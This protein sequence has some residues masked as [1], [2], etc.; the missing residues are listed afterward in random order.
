MGFD[1]DLVV[2]GATAAAQQA[3]LRAAQWQ[4]RVAWVTQGELGICDR[5]N[6]PPPL[7]S[8]RSSA[9]PDRV[10]SLSLAG[11]DVLAQR[12]EFHPH[13]Q[14]ALTV[15][16][17]ALR[18]RFYL[19]ALRPTPILPP[20]AVLDPDVTFTC[21]TLSHHPVNALPTSWSV[22]GSSPQTFAWAQWLSSQGH[23]VNLTVASAAGIPQPFPSED[24]AVNQLCVAHWQAQGIAVRSGAVRSGAG[25]S[26]AEQQGEEAWGPEG[27]GPASPLG[28]R[29]VGFLGEAPHTWVDAGLGLDRLGLSN[30]DP[31]AANGYGQ[32]AH[33]QVY[34]CG[35]MRG[36]YGLPVLAAQE[37]T[38]A[39]D[40]ALGQRP[41]PLYYAKIPYILPLDPPVLRVGL[42]EAQGRR[43][44]RRQ[45]IISLVATPLDPVTGETRWAKVVLLGSG[46]I[47]GFHGVGQGLEGLLGVM[48]AAI[49]QGV[50]LGQLGNWAGDAWSYG[51][52][53][54][55][56]Q[57]WQRWR[58][59]D[60]PPFERRLRWFFNLQRT[61]NF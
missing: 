60:F 54:D 32:T 33:A 53:M 11:V 38:I 9:K 6:F 39:V 1:Y 25:R 46:R 29:A 40:H 45:R 19:L 15:G 57:Q 51:V 24:P 8:D 22:L 49:G 61:G 55:W 17:R 23:R 4:A 48:A 18:S 27:V 59:A 47:V 41:Q 37:A 28:A 12:G 14:V 44:F 13:P 58:L 34:V 30:T 16:D 56:G 2:V 3:A 42:T 31:I 7:Q 21:H 52:V 20:I 36:G 26:G 35:G 10:G 50:P 5:A 43:F